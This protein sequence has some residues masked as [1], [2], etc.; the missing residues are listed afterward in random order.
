M[1]Q[2]VTGSG[3][4]TYNTNFKVGDV[5]THR[6]VA[7]NKLTSVDSV[8]QFANATAITKITFT[9]PVYTVH[10]SEVTGTDRYRVR[11][12][13]LSD[14]NATGYNFSKNTGR[15]QYI[16]GPILTTNLTASG[17][18][19]DTLVFEVTGATS[20]TIRYFSNNT[21]SND[22]TINANLLTNWKQWLNQYYLAIFASNNYT[23]NYRATKSAGATED[24]ILSR[25]KEQ[26][27]YYNLNGDV[28]QSSAVTT[29]STAGEFYLN[30]QVTIEVN[31]NYQYEKSDEPSPGGEDEPE[32][33]PT[34]TSKATLSLQNASGFIQFNQDESQVKIQLT[35]T[36]KSSTNFSTTNSSSWDILYHTD[37]NSNYYLLPS[38]YTLSITYANNTAQISFDTA[39][40]TWH[41]DEW[42]N[43]DFTT[44]P[45]LWFA[46][47]I[48]ETSDYDATFISFQSAIPTTIISSSSSEEP[49]PSITPIDVSYTT[50]LHLAQSGYGVGI[51]NYS[52]GTLEHPHFD[53]FY[54]AYFFNG[55][56]T[57]RT[58][59]P[60]FI[61]FGS[62]TLAGLD[63]Y[64]R[65]SY[66]N[67][68]ASF[69]TVPYV[70]LTLRVPVQD[71]VIPYAMNIA[72]EDI[73]T[74]HFRIK[75]NG[76]SYDASSV[77]NWLA[78]G[79]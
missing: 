25:T 39:V 47:S 16:S 19:S 55:I 67:F 37:T 43:I 24:N 52:T 40:R 79:P 78:I 56:Q 74:E 36:I 18:T 77:I 32:P 17:R 15:I 12:A 7:L 49:T 41:E 44:A 60:F 5:K 61:Y 58:T 76:A 54:P 62:I 4:V 38:L 53:C 14:N 23:A 8:G 28:Q 57:G 46:L 26:I 42:T 51:G 45:K 30:N 2:I 73:T 48:P 71:T 35:G 50:N 22:V 68:P 31:Y 33:T 21:L 3:I 66:I 13:I 70:F 72:V 65:T 59:S 75:V 10:S 11:V 27:G 20:Q 63:G 29:A 1:G 64:K 6:V 9:V 69:S 34:P